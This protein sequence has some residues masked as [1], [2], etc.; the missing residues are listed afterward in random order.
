[1]L[2]PWA[3]ALLL[4]PS[5]ADNRKTSLIRLISDLGLGIAVP[6]LKKRATIRAITS[7]SAAASPHPGGGEII[8]LRWRFR[9]PQVA[10]SIGL[11]W[12]FQ[13]ARAL[14]ERLQSLSPQVTSSPESSGK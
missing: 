13:S 11:G 10:L 12:R 3:M 2:A 1:M 9:R 14:K 8:G 6:R 4:F 5:I 7:M